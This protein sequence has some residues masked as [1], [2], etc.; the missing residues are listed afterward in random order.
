MPGS[1]GPQV[2]L[3]N[4]QTAGHAGFGIPLE[5]THLGVSQ[6]TSIGR[7]PEGDTN[8]PALRSSF[9]VRT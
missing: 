2:N 7:T 8:T 3:L 5:R 1:G 9:D 6:L 4:F